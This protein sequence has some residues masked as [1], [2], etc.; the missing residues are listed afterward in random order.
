MTKRT[1]K[2]A[3]KKPAPAID[4]DSLTT[5]QKLVMAWDDITTVEGAKER[6]Y[7]HHGL[8]TVELDGEEWAVGTD[9]E[10]DK[11]AASAIEDSL[12]AFNASFIISHCEL[13]DALESAVQTW[14]QERCEGC[15]DDVRQMVESAKGGLDLF[16]ENAVSADGR[17]HFL[18]G[19]DGDEVELTGSDGERLYAYRLN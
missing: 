12:W 6:T 17:G 8:W 2:T 7:D 14:Q 9:A 19:Y 3:S 10:A 11:A 1:K 16:I 13:P 5:E 15:N 4:L 18:S